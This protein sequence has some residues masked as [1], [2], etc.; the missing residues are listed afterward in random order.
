MDQRVSASAVE[1]KGPGHATSHQLVG[2]SIDDKTLSSQH[3]GFRPQDVRVDP[4]AVHLETNHEGVKQ[5]GEQK[6]RK[7]GRE[8]RLQRFFSRANDRRTTKTLSC[9][10]SEREPITSLRNVCLH[11]EQT[12]DS[13]NSDNS[14]AADVA[15][16]QGRLVTAALRG[17]SDERRRRRPRTEEPANGH[18]HSRR[19]RDRS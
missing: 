6:L 11:P 8:V 19:T 12:P 13:I 7:K 3:V 14:A 10:P 15:R 1:L 4:A 2:K 9:P 18:P 16:R 5:R 17:C